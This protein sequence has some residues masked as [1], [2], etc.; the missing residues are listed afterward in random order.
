MAFSL[1]RATSRP[2]FQ[3]GVAGWQRQVPFA[4]WRSRV[5]AQQ[6]LE[7]RQGQNANAEA[8][9]YLPLIQWCERYRVIRGAPFSLERFKPLK[10]IYEDDHPWQV[11]IKPAQVGVSEYAISLTIWAMLMA[12]RQWAPGQPGLTVG[13]LFPTK[14]A[15]SDFSKQRFSGLKRE[16]DFLAALFSDSEFD[17]VGFK[18]INDSYLYLRG[19]ASEDG[20]QSFPADILVLDEYDRMSKEAVE[21]VRKRMRQSLVKREV[22]ISTPTQPETGVHELYLASDQQVWEV[23]CN[24]CGAFTELD[25]WRDV[26]ANGRPYQE[27]KRLTREE[28]AAAQWAVHCPA[29]KNPMD[30]FADG[31]WVARRPEV[32]TIRGRQIPA[33]C[34][35]AISLEELARDAISKDPTVLTQF[36]NLALGLPYTAGGTR[37]TTEMLNKLFVELPNGELPQTQHW[38]AVTMGVDVNGLYNYWIEGTSDAG[39]RCVLDAGMVESWDQVDGL[40]R[41]FKVV[42]CVVDKAP[43]MH[44]AKEFSKRWKGR[45][46]RGYYPEKMDNDLFRVGSALRQPKSESRKRAEKQVGKLAAEEDEPDTVRINRTMACDAVFARVAELKIAMPENLVRDEEIRKQLCAPGRVLEK[47]KHGDYV[48]SWQHTTP[49]DYF[50]A[51]LYCM[52]AR[53]LMPRQMPGALVHGKT[54][55]WSPKNG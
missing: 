51:Q 31:R 5:R 44:S 1:R 10:A 48:A 23:P 9:G 42:S 27:W 15:L 26:R 24:Q 52:I 38:L 41:Q 8:D 4:D 37:I 49:D 29:C 54:K 53:A 35:P 16:S 33:L 30:R 50:H 20:L 18:Q 43:E 14:A 32:K 3:K 34:F 46:K 40:M 39:V 36:Y 55:G 22:C 47:N 21:Q 17:D 11:I 6:V 7:E 25:Y 28:I 12:Y 19:A 45:V 2:G 13:Y